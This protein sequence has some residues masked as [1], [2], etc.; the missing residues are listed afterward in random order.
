MPKTTI[1]DN[2]PLTSNVQASLA[3]LGKRIVAARKQRKLTQRQL[4][5][6][7]E[8][9][10]QTMLFVEQGRPT[11]QIGHYARALA[12][13]E[14]PHPPSQ[15]PK[16]ADPKPANE[17]ANLIRQHL[18]TAQQQA[19]YNQRLEF[20]YN[21]SNPNIPED[22]LIRKVVDKGRFHDLAVMCKQFGIERVR[23]LASDQILSSTTLQRAFQNIE[24][25]FENATVQS[26]SS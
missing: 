5:S 9:S 8:I 13:L 19:P 10:P 6:M 3:T 26:Y 4:A 20:A 1:L 18:T 14:A 25:G 7:L 17:R 22:T 24:Q 16:P 23:S 2:L 11:V 12:L 15:N 21:W